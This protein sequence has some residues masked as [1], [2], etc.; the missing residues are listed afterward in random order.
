MKLHLQHLGAWSVVWWWGRD[1]I[2]NHK[3]C[4]GRGALSVNLLC[5]F[6]VGVHQNFRRRKN[7]SIGKESHKQE[8][9]AGS[10]GKTSCCISYFLYAASCPDSHLPDSDLILRFDRWTQ[11]PNGYPTDHKWS[12][13]VCWVAV[14]SHDL[15]RRCRCKLGP[16][17]VTS[18]TGL[19]RPGDWE[20]I[21]QTFPDGSPEHTYIVYNRFWIYLRFMVLML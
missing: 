20:N 8:N 5:L 16:L 7:N 4:K 13:T 2:I 17:T 19:F 11:W 10:G 21:H 9:M 12:P 15:V 3:K 14:T 6:Y 18:R 1:Q